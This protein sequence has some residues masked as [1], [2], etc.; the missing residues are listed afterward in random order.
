MPSRG[1]AQFLADSPDRVTLLT[2][3]R[4]ASGSPSSVADSLSMSHRSVQRNLSRFAERGWAEKRDGA[5]HLTTTGALVVDE[6]TTYLDAV[7]RIEEYDA[8]F[9]NLP[10]REHA[11]DPRWLEDATLVV[12][13]SEDPQA[14]V[15][16]YV[17]SVR[18]FE[19]ERI[20]MLSPVLSRLFHDAHAKLA[21]RG[22]HT[23]LVLSEAMIERA[24]ELNPAEFEVVVS[25]PV[26]DLYCHHDPIDLGLTLG[27]R[28]VL[29]GAYDEHGQMQAC[30]EASNEALLEWTDELYER[31]RERAEPIKPTQN[32]PLVGTEG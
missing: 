10:D 13:T 25:L 6:Y 2:H 4:E 3:L 11:P 30:V 5:Y 31:Y 12:A 22:V 32:R 9:E 24:R 16:H 29:I 28:R 1:S 27:D 15:N 18:A 21:L 7:S 14:P 26:L 20:R 23:E 17:K 8:F 19:S